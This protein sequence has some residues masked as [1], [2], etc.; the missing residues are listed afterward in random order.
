MRL[1][2]KKSLIEKRTISQAIINATKPKQ[3]F[4][5]NIDVN[6]LYSKA[7]TTGSQDTMNMSPPQSNEKLVKSSVIGLEGRVK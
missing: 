7:K 3:M 4:K 1:V 5:V 2:A 6:P